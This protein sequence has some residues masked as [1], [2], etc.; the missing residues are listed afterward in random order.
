M[1]KA[2]LII[3]VQKGMFQMDPPVYNGGQ[4]LQN[5]KKV[6]SCAR[7]KDIPL[8]HVQHNG[9]VG[10]PLEQ[11]TDGWAIHEEIAPEENDVVLTKIPLIVFT[12][13]PSNTI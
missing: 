5:L 8:L 3:D 6:I 9:P 1:K 11:G 13:P 12:K 7:E 4:L 10:S 2:I